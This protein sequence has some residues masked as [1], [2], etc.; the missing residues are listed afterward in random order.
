MEGMYRGRRKCNK[1]RAMCTGNPRP[2]AHK[3]ENNG[4]YSYYKV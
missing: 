2:Q 3:C 1:G 4:T